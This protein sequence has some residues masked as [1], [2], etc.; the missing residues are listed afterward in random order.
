MDTHLAF[1]DLLA[2]YNLIQTKIC[3]FELILDIHSYHVYL[4]SINNQM[5]HFKLNW[6]GFSMV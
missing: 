5:A 3:S 2:K 6:I 1:I 4:A